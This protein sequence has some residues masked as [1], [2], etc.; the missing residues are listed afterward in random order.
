[1]SSVDISHKWLNLIGIW[2]VESKFSK[3]PCQTTR[4]SEAIKPTRTK[5]AFEQICA[6]GPELSG[7][8]RWMKIVCRLT[9]WMTFVTSVQRCFE[10]VHA[11]DSLFFCRIW[12]EGRGGIFAAV[13]SERSCS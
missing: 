5:V 2:N 3:H 10:I 4:T 13:W 12:Q 9:L 8:V 6:K 11:S 1:M 7:G